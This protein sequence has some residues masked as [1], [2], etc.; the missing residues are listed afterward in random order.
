MDNREIVIRFMAS[1]SEFSTQRFS[2]NIFLRVYLLII[3]ILSQ[4]LKN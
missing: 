3:L 2:L 1:V 4:E